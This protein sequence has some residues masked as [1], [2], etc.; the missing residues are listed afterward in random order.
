M[1][2][3]DDFPRVV[4]ANLRPEDS[5]ALLRFGDLLE[6]MSDQHAKGKTRGGLFSSLIGGTGA[7]T[8]AKLAKDAAA[9]LAT[10]KR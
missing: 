2:G 6:R 9:I 7:G 10:G 1:S 4:L 8:A 3:D 5:G